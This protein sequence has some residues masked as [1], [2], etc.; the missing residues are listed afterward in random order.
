MEYQRSEMSSESSNDR[1]TR[2]WR[3]AYLVSTPRQ[4]L[5]QGV[6]AAGEGGGVVG[7]G[8]RLRGRLIGF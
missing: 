3:L 7:G 4:E 1:A 2:D 8:G 5:G 6:E